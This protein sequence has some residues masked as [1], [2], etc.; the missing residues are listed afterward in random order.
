LTARVGLPPDTGWKRGADADY[1]SE[2]VA[3]WADSYDWRVHERRIQSLPWAEVDVDGA[4]YRVLHQRSSDEAATVVLLHGWPDSVL[5]YERALPLLTDVN[6]VVPALPGFPYAPPLK[7]PG[8]SMTAM[9]AAVEAMMARLGY[10]SYVVSGGDVYE[11]IHSRRLRTDVR[12]AGLSGRRS[13]LAD[14]G[15]GLRLGT[16]DETSHVGGGTG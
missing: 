15:G 13:G 14:D 16:G 9:A 3:Y 11:F 1:L 7:E 6:V 2:L 4:N 12:R 5:R 10:E 8:M